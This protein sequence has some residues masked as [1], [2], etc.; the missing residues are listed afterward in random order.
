MSG[1]SRR[2]HQLS[3]DG[4]TKCPHFTHRPRR[5]WE[6]LLLWRIAT[7]S[8]S[9]SFFFVGQIKG[10]SPC[11]RPAYYAL[12]LLDLSENRQR[13]CPPQG[14]RTFLLTFV[15]AWT[16]VWSLAWRNPPDLSFKK[17][18]SS[19]RWIRLHRKQI[20][21]KIRITC[22]IFCNLRRICV[23]Q[24]P[25]FWKHDKCCAILISL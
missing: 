14:E 17:S 12:S 16:K 1:A 24:P 2:P 22:G 13:R 25:F 6:S 9:L 8:L 19:N 7:V 5:F 4:T 18:N 20:N 15:A 3:Q 11:N 10:K 21:N 23:V